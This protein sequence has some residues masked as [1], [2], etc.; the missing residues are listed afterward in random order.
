MIEKRSIS[1]GLMTINRRLE[2]E[3][4]EWLVSQIEI[5]S[6]KTYGEMLY[7]LHHT[8]FVWFI[9]NDDNRARD[10]EDLRHEFLGERR[11]E[12][13]NGVSILEVLVALSRRIEFNGGGRAPNWAWVL[14]QN[15]ELH[16]MNDPLNLRKSVKIDDILEALVFRTY[17]P[18]GQGGL[19]PLIDAKEDQT[20]LELWYQMSAYILENCDL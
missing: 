14:I 7:K 1:G 13:Q 20:K 12:F 5:R 18:S 6:T 2:Q 11:Y 10:G 3:Y 16:K 15:L 19:F 17:E 4:F 9:P 8:E